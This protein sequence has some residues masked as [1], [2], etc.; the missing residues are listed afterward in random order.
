LDIGPL[1]FVTGSHFL[2]DRHGLGDVSEVQ[3]GVGN[4]HDH[5]RRCLKKPKRSGFGSTLST[6]T[7]AEKK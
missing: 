7:S 4:G 5:R 6:T 1:A 2:Y 3:V